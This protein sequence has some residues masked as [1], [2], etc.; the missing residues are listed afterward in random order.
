VAFTDKNDRLRYISWMARHLEAAEEA[1]EGKGF[2][3]LLRAKRVYQ[4]II[5]VD[6]VSKVRRGQLAPT[7]PMVDELYRVGIVPMNA[8]ALRANRPWDD[9]PIRNFPTPGTGKRGKPS[10]AEKKKKKP[11]AALTEV[12]A[13]PEPEQVN[14]FDAIAA[15][16][17]LSVRDKQRLSAIVALMQ[18]SVP[19]NFAVEVAARP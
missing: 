5:G 16:T 7:A 2:S 18:C 13:P 10:N 3:H 12:V 14:I 9:E 1:A 4:D 6:K 17:A 11:E 15:D 8:E 19:V